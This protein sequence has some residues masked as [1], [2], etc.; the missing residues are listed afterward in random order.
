[1]ERVRVTATQMLVRHR[2]TRENLERHL[3]LIDAAARRD[4]RLIL[5][6]ELSLT[7]HN[8]SPEIVRDAMQAD[9]PMVADLDPEL[10]ALVR[11][12][13]WFQL[14]K[15]RPEAYAELSRAL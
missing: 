10:L 5:F 11:S 9:G 3:A 2:A 14:R 13:P 4:V 1:M 8:G 12:S 15:R 6:P 7:G